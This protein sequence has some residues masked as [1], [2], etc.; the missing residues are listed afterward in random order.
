MTRD[1]TEIKRKCRQR[2]MQ[3]SPRLKGEAH[4]AAA[5]SQPVGAEQAKAKPT[6]MLLQIET[7]EQKSQQANKGKELGTDFAKLQFR[8]YDDPNFGKLS[9]GQGPY[10]PK[11]IPI[12]KHSSFSSSE[13]SS[14]L[15]GFMAK[16]QEASQG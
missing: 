7:E 15:E 2:L 4:Q 6:S 12:Q 8:P 1:L 13:R 11:L 5:T 14:D 3:A 10:S 9:K 16:N